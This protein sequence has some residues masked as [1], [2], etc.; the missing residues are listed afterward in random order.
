MFE[1]LFTWTLEK[2][3]CQCRCAYF[4]A[5]YKSPLKCNKR[6]LKVLLCNS[7]LE[8]KHLSGCRICVL[9]S[10]VNCIMKEPNCRTPQSSVTGDLLYSVIKPSNTLWV[11]HEKASKSTLANYNNNVSVAAVWCLCGSVRLRHA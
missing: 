10:V 8:M 2:L 6:V 9:L 1:W 5:K 3:I 7:C 4:N 11:S